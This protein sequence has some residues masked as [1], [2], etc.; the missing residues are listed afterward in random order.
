VN[1]GFDGTSPTALG[2]LAQALEM[3]RLSSPVSALA[4]Q[5]YVSLQAA[6]PLAAELN[7]HLADGLSTRHLAQWL[8]LLARE[9][10][11]RLVAEGRVQLV[12]TGPEVQGS[13][14]RD[15]VVVV[16][17]LFA[18]ARE[19]VLIAGYVVAQGDRIFQSLATRMDELPALRV[20]LFLNVQRGYRDTRT[21]AEILREFAEEFRARQWPGTPVPEVFYDPRALSLEHGPRAV[22]HAKCVVVDQARAFIT[23]ANFTEAAQERNIEAGVL[24]EDVALATALTT[25][26]ETL[27]TAGIL[28]RLAGVSASIADA[29]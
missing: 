24:V 21:D 12:W 29:R 14:S 20:R 9:R 28:K 22:L 15:T 3:G 23:S 6:A 1:P 25:Q 26:F 17:E 5:N 10:Q 18:S 19:R 16:Q 2:D 27:V 13:M 8:R 7:Q 4:L 11:D